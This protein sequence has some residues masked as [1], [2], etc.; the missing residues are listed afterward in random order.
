M[1]VM[2][3]YGE[4]KDFMHSVKKKAALKSVYFLPSFK[5]TKVLTDLLY[6]LTFLVFLCICTKSSTRRKKMHCNS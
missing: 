4:C 1:V 5:L 2:K 3:K 6:F